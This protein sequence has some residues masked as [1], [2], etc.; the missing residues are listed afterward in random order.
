MCFPLHASHKRINC[1]LVAMVSIH[2]FTAFA[3]PED[4]LADRI[5][6]V[7]TLLLTVVAFKFVVADSIPKVCRHRL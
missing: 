4:N 3:L 2:R 7:L 1:L 5:N 6:I